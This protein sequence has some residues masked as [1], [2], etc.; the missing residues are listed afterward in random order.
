ME[1]HCFDGASKRLPALIELVV[2]RRSVPGDGYLSLAKIENLSELSV[3][4]VRHLVGIGFCVSSASVNI[5]RITIEER[6]WIIVKL[7]NISSRTILNLTRKSRSAMRGS[8]STLPKPTRDHAR[9]T[10]TTGIFAICPPAKGSCLG[11]TSSGLPGTNK[12]PLAC[13]TSP[14]TWRGKVTAA[15]NSSRKK[16]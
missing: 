12:E 2:E 14:I 7:D 8:I 13:S 5:R 9:H 6:S 15:A 11:Q 4:C 1:W 16:A 10:C 3:L